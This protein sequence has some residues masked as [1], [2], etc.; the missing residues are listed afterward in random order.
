MYDSSL[1]LHGKFRPFNNCVVETQRPM[2]TVRF[3]ITNGSLF[4][5]LDGRIPIIH[6][7]RRTKGE[8]SILS[9]YSLYKS[10][11]YRV[12]LRPLQWKVFTKI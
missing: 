6:N 3:P 4:T 8:L 11:I 10:M 9:S 1:G 7:Y 2:E 5:S 12:M